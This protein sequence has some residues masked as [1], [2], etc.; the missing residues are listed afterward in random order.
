MC[1]SKRCGHWQNTVIVDSRTVT[2]ICRWHNRQKLHQ[3]CRTR[4]TT[5]SGLRPL[6]DDI[7]IMERESAKRA[8]L[9][10]MIARTNDPFA[11]AVRA[12]S[13]VAGDIAQV[14]AD[15]AKYCSSPDCGGEVVGCAVHEADCTDNW[16][17]MYPVCERHKGWEYA[18]MEG[19]SIYL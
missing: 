9:G 16:A 15:G 2:D 12:D 18:K 4:E 8:L 13:L 10:M 3:L 17:D 14:F 7:L 19:V 6:R 11:F 1:Q 5:T